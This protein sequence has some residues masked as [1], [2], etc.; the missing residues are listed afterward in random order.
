M[1]KL[2]VTNSSSGL[3]HDIIYKWNGYQEN[4]DYYSVPVYLEA[5]SDR[6]KDKYLTFINNL[7]DTIINT[8]TINDH[9]SCLKKWI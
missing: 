8:K 4:S 5:N 1:N 6:F 2:T 9:L 3:T 7:G